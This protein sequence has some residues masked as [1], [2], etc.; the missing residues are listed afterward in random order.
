MVPAWLARVSALTVCLCFLGP[1]QRI[2]S[3]CNSARSW[4][5]CQFAEIAS[6]IQAVTLS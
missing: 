4:G 1:I 2:C 6:I 3:D 5:T